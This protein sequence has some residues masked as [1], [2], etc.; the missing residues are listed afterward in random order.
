MQSVVVRNLLP[1]NNPSCSIFPVTRLAQ[2]T[3][4][5]GFIESHSSEIPPMSKLDVCKKK[6][7]MVKED[8]SEVRI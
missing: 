7:E 5:R 6:G 1:V 2:I 8:Q 3:Y 4:I